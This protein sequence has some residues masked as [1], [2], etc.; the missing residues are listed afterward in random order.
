MVLR[1]TRG[2]AIVSGG[3]R[4]A[5]TSVAMDGALAT[6]SGGGPRLRSAVRDHRLWSPPGSSH[7]RSSNSP[8]FLNASEASE[9]GRVDGSGVRGVLSDR[10]HLGTEF[11][12]DRRGRGGGSDTAP[13]QAGPM[14]RSRDGW[15]ARSHCQ[16]AVAGR[17]VRRGGRSCRHS[18]VRQMAARMRVR[19]PLATRDAGTHRNTVLSPA[20]G[21]VALAAHALGRRRTTGA[22]QAGVVTIKATGPWP[23]ATIGVRERGRRESW[24]RCTVVGGGARGQ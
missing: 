10:R 2:W 22:R 1:D 16:S 7:R 24:E 19:R 3:V 14:D 23:H 8:G 15:R 17:A 21:G 20:I 18:G 6:V 12:R 13:G 11:A 9:S 5:E 4:A